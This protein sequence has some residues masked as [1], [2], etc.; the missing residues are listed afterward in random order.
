LFRY[1]QTQKLM[2]PA[3]SRVVKA[4]N[5]AYDKSLRQ[6][7]ISC[8][9]LQVLHDL[10]F[11]EDTPNELLETIKLGVNEELLKPEIIKIRKDEINNCINKLKKEGWTD[12]HINAAIQEIAKKSEIDLTEIKNKKETILQTD[13]P[14]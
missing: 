8:P 9:E 12:E 2:K 7:K 5:E 1:R 14:F 3:P 4:L 13:D 6:T 10:A 11:M